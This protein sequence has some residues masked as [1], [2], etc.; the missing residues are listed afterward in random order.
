MGAGFSLA[1][2]DPFQ[3]YGA[4]N[5]RGR[6][7]PTE[8]YLTALR[9]ACV[10]SGVDG[11]DV[12]VADDAPTMPFVCA[13]DDG[14]TIAAFPRMPLTSLEDGLRM[15]VIRFQQMVADGTLAEA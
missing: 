1:A 7:V 3:G 6:T 12:D 5:L 9:E 13:L 14:A 4:F 2:I 15:S 11:V 10:A 8:V